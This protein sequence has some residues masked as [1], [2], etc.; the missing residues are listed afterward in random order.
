VADFQL[1]RLESEPGLHDR[2]EFDVAVTAVSFDV[3]AQMRQL[4][5]A[6]LTADD[7]AQLRSALTT[8]TSS[9]IERLDRDTV[10]I[11]LARSKRMQICASCRDPLRRAAELLK[12]VRPAIALPFAHVARAAFV[13]TAFTRSAVTADLATAESVEDY[14]RS[15]GT[16]S[17]QLRADGAAVAADE[18]SW[19]D[20]V[21]RY[22]DLRPGTYDPAVPRYRDAPEVYL[23]PFVS[24]PCAEA[25][26]SRGAV[27]WFTAAA[28]VVSARLTQL[29]LDCDA[30]A[31]ARFTR[32]AMT[33][34]EAGKFEL[35]CWISAI[36]EALVETAAECGQAADDVSYWRLS[37]VRQMARGAVDPHRLE[38]RVARRRMRHAVTQRLHLPATINGL[39]DLRCF[40]T[41]AG[42]PTYVGTGKSIG[43]VI[44]QPAPADLPEKGIVVL[45]SADPGFEWLFSRPLAGIITMY[46]GANSHMA[47]RCAESG[48]PAAIGVGQHI[49]AQLAGAALVQLD[50]AGQTIEIIR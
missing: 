41:H 39:T 5:E 43:R 32:R 20:Y 11:K 46:G 29:G 45:P 38:T 34:R 50:C 48:I 40:S 42:R 24:S 10:M 13:A 28:G 31:L 30:A 23:R 27:P 9:A 17:A 37:D 3:E 4:K 18:L 14:M 35:S 6:G 26:P 2:L 16:I 25:A 1:H 44:V 47:V 33:A 49:Y 7:C 22:G 12:E 36:L 19:D 21:A 8:I 15:L